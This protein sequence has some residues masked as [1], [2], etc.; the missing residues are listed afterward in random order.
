MSGPTRGMAAGKPQFSEGF[1]EE[2]EE[3]AALSEWI[4]EATGIFQ[5]ILETSPDGLCDDWPTAFYDD[6]PATSHLCPDRNRE[7]GPIKTGQYTTDWGLVR[8]YDRS[9]TCV[10]QRQPV[11][12]ILTRIARLVQEPGPEESPGPGAS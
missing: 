7:H 3:L 10:S 11:W 8:C 6:D 4:A 9:C 12:G 5:E 1:R 2:C